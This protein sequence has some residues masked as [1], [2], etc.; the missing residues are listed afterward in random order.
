MSEILTIDEVAT[1]L[2]KSRRWV[3]SFVR[4][5]GIGRLAGRTRLF[6]MAD[7]HQL[8]EA[9][10]CPSSSTRPGR[11]TRTGRSA[12]RTSS[13]T[14]SEALALAT[15]K[16]QPKSYGRSKGKS[17]VVSLPSREN[18][19]SRQQPQPTSWFIY[20]G[21]PD[22]EEIESRKKSGY[23]CVRVAVAPL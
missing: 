11:A 6:T 19:R 20:C 17:N 9:L 4:G 2:H 14:L 10:P 15:E 7:L 1:R 12:A 16:S 22:D 5:R 21:W 18:R 23:K 3:R 13:G 8:I